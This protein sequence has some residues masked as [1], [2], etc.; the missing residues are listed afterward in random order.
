[1][2]SLFVDPSDVLLFRDGRSFSAAS[3]DRLAT[4]RFPPPPTVFYGA[5]RSALLGTHG[6]DVEAPDFGLTGPV[7]E[8][9]GT[10][11]EPGTLSIDRC[12]LA[13]RTDGSI[14]RLY[15]VPNHVLVRKADRDRPPAERRYTA[16]RPAAD[17]GAPSGR[18]NLPDETGLLWTDATEDTVYTQAGGY[19]PEPAFRE[20]LSGTL[21]AVGPN[22]VRQEEIAQVEP[23][24]SVAIGESGT[25]RDGRLFTVSFTRPGLDIGFLL[26]VTGDGSAFDEDGWLRLGGEARSARYTQREPDSPREADPPREADSAGSAPSPDAMAA[27]IREHGQFRLALATPV[28]FENGWRPDALDEEGNGMIGGCPVSLRGA[29]VGK[30]VPLGG[31]NMAEGR[32]RP[33]RRAVPA[34]SVYFFELPN[35]ADAPTLLENGPTCSLAPTAFDRKRGLGIAHIGAPTP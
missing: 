34:G 4:G 24:T 7:G 27:S 30:P 29:A 35:P 13:R 12:A 17:A 1:M 32:P 26:S 21:G 22:L 23:R 10:Q 14:E 20:A 15:P 28:A 25:G 31:W 6:A 9:V 11:T 8:T 2:T 18:T 19:L 5:L 3:G 33:T 16:L